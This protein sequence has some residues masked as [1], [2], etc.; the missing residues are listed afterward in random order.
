MIGSE[1][2]VELAAQRAHEHGVGGQGPRG[3]E[4]PRRGGEETLI[5][6]AEEPGLPGMGVERA[7]RQSRRRDGKP[8]AQRGERDAADADDPLGRELAGDFAQRQVR[9]DEDD[10]QAGHHQHH[11]RLGASGQAPEELRHSGESVPGNM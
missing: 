3:A 5:L 11:H 10:T 8:I 4:R 6:V 2:R 9:R 7:H 1:D